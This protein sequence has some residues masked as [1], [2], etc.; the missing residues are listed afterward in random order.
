VCAQDDAARKHDSSNSKISPYTIPYLEVA[1]DDVDPTNT[2]S[3]SSGIKHPEPEHR[4]ESVVVSGGKTTPSTGD[5]QPVASTQR[6]IAA[7]SPYVPLPA[8]GCDL[9]ISPYTCVEQASSDSSAGVSAP[10][11]RA[12]ADVSPQ[13]TV[14]E[15]GEG[16]KC[17]G[18]IP[19]PST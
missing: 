5:V 11:S 16:T 18:Y 17:D 7:D 6:V 19:W 2:E 8:P 3:C 9:P 14:I 13:N 10:G 1:D 15:G 12:S 4:P